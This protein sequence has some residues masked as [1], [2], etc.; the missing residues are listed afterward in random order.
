MASCSTTRWVSTSPYVKLTVEQTAST[1]TTAT[2]TYTLQYISDYAADASSRAYT[3]KINGSTVASGSYNIDGVTGTKTVKTGTVTITKGTSAKS[4]AFSVS[5]DFKLTWSGNYAGTLSASGSISVAAKTSYTVKYNANGGSGA[6]SA[7]TKWHD[8]AL[9]LST[10]KPTRSGYTFK[11]WATSSTATSATYSAG[12][13]YTA[14]AAATLYAVWATNYTQPKI[15]GM[16]VAR[17]NSAG[18]AD[19]NGTYCR[20]KFNWSSSKSVTSVQIKFTTTALQTVTV[21]ASGTS[22]SVNQVIGGGA[23]STANMYVI[24]AYVGDGTKTVNASRTLPGA[25]I[26]LSVK[27]N[28]AIA[29]GRRATTDGYA[30]FGFHGKFDSNKKIFGVTTTGTIKEALNP[31][32]SSGNTVLGYGNYSTKSGNTYIY[33]RDVYIGASNTADGS[34]TY[35]PYYSRGD[36]ISVTLKT[37]GYV[38]NSGTE[39]HFLVPLTKPII[40]APTVTV[41][42]NSGFVLRQG[43]KYTHGCSSSAYATPSKYSWSRDA[44]MGI[45]VVATFSSTT[46]V[47]NNDSIGI[48][49]SGTITFS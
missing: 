6:P 46:D 7:Q 42:S 19:A 35:K 34:T 9:T 15:S 14:N 45:T 27:K 2:L 33:G 49:W 36:T 4:I 47:T 23:L 10:T 21:S 30:E 17:C 18:T 31:Q 40:G 5:F 12:G 41:T 39:V 22:G 26:P 37:A 32:D 38:T 20:V 25:V 8:T 3:I 16:S 44:D 11:G 29:F 43:T 48:V 1:A 13:S 28:A 24:T